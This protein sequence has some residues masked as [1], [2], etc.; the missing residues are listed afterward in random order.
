MRDRFRDGMFVTRPEEPPDRS[1]PWVPPTGR[2]TRKALAALDRPIL[3]WQE[4]CYAQFPADETGPLQREAAK[5][6]ARPTRRLERL[7]QP[8]E[9]SGPDELAA[10]EAACRDVDGVR[11]APRCLDDFDERACLA[12]GLRDSDDGDPVPIDPQALDE[13]LAWAEAGVCV[14]Q[15]SLPWPFQD[16]LLYGQADNRPAHRVL[17]TYAGLLSRKRPRDAARWRRALAFLN[18]PDSIGAR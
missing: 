15:A 9:E 18:P 5:L 13:A 6:G 16:C 11:L 3:A 12:A 14:L 1:M 8:N 10:Y 7:W 17:R 4:D 2:I